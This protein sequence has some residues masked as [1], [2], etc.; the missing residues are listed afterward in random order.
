MYNMFNRIFLYLKINA[1]NI[2]KIFNYN[3]LKIKIDFNY[4][5]IFDK[6]KI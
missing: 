4:I 2:E 1:N 5:Y 3:N 6:H